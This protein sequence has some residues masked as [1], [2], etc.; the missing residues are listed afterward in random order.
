MHS[1]ICDACLKSG[2]FCNSCQGKIDSGE[3]SKTELDVAKFL[4]GLSGKI[5]SLEEAK[6]VKVINGHAIIIITEKGSAAKIVGKQGSVVKLLAKHF[7]KPIRVVEADD[8][9]NFINN[10]IVPA[11]AAVNVVYAGGRECY[12]IRVLKNQK[13]RLPLEPGEISV[14]MEK[15]FGKSA[16]VLFE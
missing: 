1:K 16:E 5:K 2:I 9:K 15:I 12:R 6:I 7:N 3:V 4:F 10:L 11:S 8:A 14:A 13:N